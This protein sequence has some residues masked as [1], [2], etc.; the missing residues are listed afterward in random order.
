MNIVALDI[1]LK[2]IGV[3]FATNKTPPVVCT[4]ILRKN[5]NQAASEVQAIIIEKRADI[6]V[7]G[8]PKGGASED[9]MRRRIEHF[10]GLLDFGGRVE[11]QDEY[12]SSAEAVIYSGTKKDGRLDSVAAMIILERWLDANRNQ[13]NIA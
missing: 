4:P 12:G 5:R 6:L 8:L 2:R 3:A 1:G 9:E 7:V 11:Y 10:V 13:L